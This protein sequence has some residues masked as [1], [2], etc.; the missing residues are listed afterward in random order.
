MNHDS[1][2]RKSRLSTSQDS[3]GPFATVL[4]GRNN[5]FR[6]GIRHFLAGTPFVVSEDEL[7]DPSSGA[8]CSCREAVLFIVFEDRLAAEQIEIVRNLKSQYPESRVVLLV[9]QLESHVVFNLLE[10]D[11]NGLCSTAMGR[12][13]LIKAL[14]LVMLGEVFISGSLGSAMLD[15]MRTNYRTNID[16]TSFF[17]VPGDKSPI[18][19]KLSRRETEILTCLTQGASNK[20]IGR[21]LG[22]AEETVKVRLRAIMKKVNATNRTQ[23]A[24]WAQV[25]LA[26]DD[27]KGFMSAVE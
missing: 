25:H 19:Q 11:L 21:V 8:G 22:I 13:F 3:P 5:L 20:H 12:L 27:A 18:A 10:A 24:M 26:I 6:S 16:M 17:M 4:V 23:A 7:D 15:E 1:A 14:E 2:C 9:D